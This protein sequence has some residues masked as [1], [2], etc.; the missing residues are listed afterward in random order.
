MDDIMDMFTYKDGLYTY[1]SGVVLCF[2][3]RYLFMRDEDVDDQFYGVFIGIVGLL[4]LAVTL[5]ANF[6]RVSTSSASSA[7]GGACGAGHEGDEE[8][9]K[10]GV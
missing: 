5:Y 6:I 8:E 1:I 7:S 9:G 10:K 2:L 4:M 3:G